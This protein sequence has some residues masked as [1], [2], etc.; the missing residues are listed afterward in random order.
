MSAIATVFET[1]RDGQNAPWGRYNA[2]GLCEFDGFVLVVALC[3]KY[4]AQLAALASAALC[5][6]PSGTSPPPM[7]RRESY[8]MITVLV[9]ASRKCQLISPIAS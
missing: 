1:G 8:R 4:M 3:D 7:S 9:R 2:R 6:R 5:Y